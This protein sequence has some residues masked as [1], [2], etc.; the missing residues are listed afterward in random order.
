MS[1]KPIK[2]ASKTEE[3]TELTPAPLVMEN[4]RNPIQRLNLSNEEMAF[5]Q[6]MMGPVHKFTQNLIMGYRPTDNEIK[7][8]KLLIAKF[9]DLVETRD[10]AKKFDPL[11]KTL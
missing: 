10:I 4:T 7:E 6:E 5:W 1:E 9:T 3:T 8:N 11:P 2:E